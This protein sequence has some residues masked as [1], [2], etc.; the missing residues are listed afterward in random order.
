MVHLLPL[1]GSPRY[2]GS[3]PQ[4]LETAVADA[5]VLAASGFPALLLENFGDVPFFAGDVPAETVAGVTIAAEAVKR[6]TELPFGVN[7]LRNDALSAIGVAAASGASFIRVNVL[8]GVMYTDQGPIIGRAAE[9]HRKI[10]S[11]RLD[12]EVWADVMVKHSTA[13]QGLGVAQA[14]QDTVERGLAD[15]VIVS[16]SGTGVEPDMIEAK[17]VAASVPVGT[18]LVI[19]SGVTVDNLAALTEVADTVIVG[20]SLKHEGNPNSRVDPKRASLLVRAASDVGL[21]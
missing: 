17:T 18:R 7:I 20:S 10:Q 15:A 5:T 4:I 21:V 16:G 13:P 9:A 8:T 6:A 19:G 11:M 14:T 3:I 1:P 12:L 2:A